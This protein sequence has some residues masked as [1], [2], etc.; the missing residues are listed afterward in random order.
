M[1]LEQHVLQR[2]GLTPIR[3]TGTLVSEGSSK[4]PQGRRNTRHRWHEVAVYATTDGRYV[5]KVDYLTDW[6][7]ERPHRSATVCANHADLANFLTNLDPTAYVIG[8][9]DDERYDEKQRRLLLNIEL[10]YQEL[11]SAVLNLPQFQE[12]V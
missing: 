5:A 11:V 10:R 8:Y 3:F 1:P 7:T 9:P 4:P 12:A 2:T 6:I